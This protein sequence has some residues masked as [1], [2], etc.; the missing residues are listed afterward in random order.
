MKPLRFSKSMIGKAVPLDPYRRYG[1]RV[2]NIVST[3]VLHYLVHHITASSLG[4]HGLRLAV[5]FRVSKILAVHRCLLALP[6]LCLPPPLVNTQQVAQAYASG[7]YRVAQE[8]Y[9][10]AIDLDE[11]GPHTQA[12]L[13]AYWVASLMNLGENEDA[14]TRRDCEQA[15]GLI[16]VSCSRSPR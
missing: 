10:E 13:Y 1:V 7:F 4:L 12:V 2:H 15:G 6:L 14:L 16:V 3:P 11:D 9:T 5:P 8:L